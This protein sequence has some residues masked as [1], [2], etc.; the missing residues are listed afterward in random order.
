MAFSVV[1]E[2][3]KRRK[4]STQAGGSTL[5]SVPS[6]GSGFSVARE[7]MRRRGLFEN[8]DNDYSSWNNDTYNLSKR[9]QNE[10]EARKDQF[11][12]KNQF[13]SYQ[14][15]VLQ[16]TGD[17]L[18]RAYASRDYYTQYG[19][20]YSNRDQILKDINQNIDYL[21]DVRGGIVSEG[22]YWDQF[23]DEDSYNAY[24][25]MAAALADPV[26]DGI[27]SEELNNRLE[28]MKR[29]QSE[30]KNQLSERENSGDMGG[31]TLLRREYDRTTNQ[32]N[33]LQKEYKDNFFGQF[34][35]SY[36]QGRLSQDEAQA[37]NDYLTLPTEENRKRAETLSAVLKQFQSQNEEVLKDDADLPLISQSLAGYLPQFL[38][39]TKATIS[40]GLVGFGA[41]SAVPVLGSLAGAKAGA[42]AASG[43]Y[44]Y[45]TMR[46]SAFRDLLKLGVDEETA[47]AA[48]NDEAIVSAMIEMGDTL[49]D[50][51]GLSYGVGSIIDVARKG[52]TKK[53]AKE[54]AEAVAESAAKKL[55]KG[56]GRYGLTVGG[57][58]VEEGA[59]QAV[60]IANRERLK[61]GGSGI[62]D[63]AKRSV[64]TGW[65][66]LRGA[67]PEARA[68]ILEAAEEGGKIAA[69][70]GGLNAGFTAVGNR[71]LNT[72]TEHRQSV[73]PVEKVV[74]QVESPVLS[75]QRNSGINLRD[76]LEPTLIEDEMRRGRPEP[77]METTQ[78]VQEQPFEPMGESQ[79]TAETAPHVPLSDLLDGGKRVDYQSLS[80]DHLAEWDQQGSGAYWM[81][82]EDKVYQMQ[83]EDHIS[84]RTPESVGSRSI[85]AFQ[86]DHPEMQPFY[87]QAAQDLIQDASASLA[88]PIDR[89]TVRGPQGKEQVSQA[90]SSKSL[91][92]AMDIGL[93][94]SEVI[95]AAEALIADKG[96]ENYAAAKRLELVLDDMLS[97]GYMDV[98]GNQHQPNEGYLQLKQEIPGYQDNREE[99]PI[100]DMDETT[101]R[102]VQSAYQAGL[103]GTPISDIPQNAT[104]AELDAYEAGRK[105]SI[106]RA[107][108][109]AVS[110]EQ[111]EAFGNGNEEI[112]LRNSGQWAGGA[113]SLGQIPGVEESTGGTQSRKA[114]GAAAD[115]ET[116]SLTY[117]KAVSTSSLGIWGGSK[118]ENIRLVTGGE[119]AAV[120]QARQ[121]ARER[122]LRLVL[123]SGSNLEI[124]KNGVTISARAYIAGDRVF[125]R[126]DHPLFT[127]DQ[128]MRHEVGHDMIAKGEIDPNAVRERILDTFGAE[129]LDSLS[130]M[131]AE[132]YEGSG[133]TAEEIW[134]DIICDS[135]ADMNIF[136]KKVNEEA[137]EW[138]LNQT[139]KA[140]EQ[141]TGTE[142]KGQPAEGNASREAGLNPAA[143]RA[144]KY[145]YDTL[146]KKP[147]MQLTL[148]DDTVQY[149]AKGNVRKQIVKDAIQ[150]AL[151]IGKVNQSGGVSVYV[152]DMG[153]DVVLSTHGL[154]HGLDRRLQQNAAV[155]LKAG[156][157]LQN[158]ILINE[159][160]PKKENAKDS[161]VLLGVAKNADN[162]LY[163]VEFVV[164]RF[165]SVVET[166][167]VLYSANA[168]KESAVL[169]APAITGNPLRITDPVIS[170][171]HLLDL[172]NIY[173]ADVLPEDVLRHFGHTERP[174][175][176]LGESALFSRETNTTEISQEQQKNLQDIQ[177]AARQAVREELERMGR[178]YGWMKPGEKPFREVQMPKRTSDDKKLSQTVR[179][180]MEAE[181]TPDDFIP[182]IEQET[183]RE[184]FSFV[185]ITNDATTRAAQKYIMDRGWSAALND[186]TTDVRKGRTGEQITAIGALLYNNAVNSGQYKAALDIL[187]DYQMAIRNSARGLQAARI[188]KT[189]TPENKLYMIRRDI[190][191][192]VEALDLPEG[193]EVPDNLADAFTKAKTEAERDKA[194]E[195][196]QQYVADQLPST[197][198]DWWT[199]LRY[200]NMLGN[201][202]T[203]VRNVSG[204]V[205]MKAVGEVENLVATV[206]ERLAMGK[207]GRT[208]SVFAGKELHR[209]ASADFE[210]VKAQA[211]GED[212]YTLGNESNSAFV[213]G[214]MDKRTIFKIGNLEIVP[215]ER[216]RKATNWAMNNG[217]FGDE[218]FSRS[219]YARALSGYLKAKGVSAEQFGDP[220]WQ[221]EHTDFLD[222]ARVFAIKRAQELTFRDHNILSDWISKVGR[223]KDTPKLAKAAAEGIMPFRRT[224][225]NV[226][227][228]A[229]EYS[230]LGLVN[231][232][233]QAV[234]LARG[235][236]NV[237]GTDVVN[238]L[239]KAL[240][241]TGIFIVGMALQNAGWLVGGEDEE[242]KKAAFQELTGH[243]T[244]SLELPD[245][246]SIT[247]DWLTPAA[248]PLFMGAQ[249][250]C[251]RQDG[252]I[253][254]KDLEQAMMSIADPM[255]QMSMMQGLSDTLDNIR[256]AKNAT[257]QY[258]A[259][260]ALGYLTQGLT[261]SL[262]GQFA[263]TTKDISTMTYVDQNSPLPNWLQKE[264]GAASRK[265][266]GSGYNQIPYIDAWGRTESTGAVAERIFNNFLNPSYV[267][268][269]EESPMEQELMRL[270]EATGEGSV[271]PSRADKKF[272]L[273]KKE[274]I[275]TAEEYTKYATK[276][277][278]T[279]YKLLTDMTSSAA[280]QLMSDKE[281]VEAVKN[282]YDYANQIAKESV[283]GFKPDEWVKNLKNI[284]G[285]CGITQGT[286]LALKAMTKEIEGLKYADKV[287]KNGKP[288]TINNSQGLQIMEKVYDSKLV[289]GLTSDQLKVLF[290]Y[291]GVGKDVRHY[292]ASKVRD[293]LEKM[294]K[295]SVG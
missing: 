151:P 99:L 112:R 178:E 254:L 34:G 42:T 221:K 108:S 252:G 230:P 59:Q 175:G 182:L 8:Q 257:L 253:E 199:A 213:S 295:R 243:Q 46:G 185:P 58:A 111:Q 95:E 19:D 238:S 196:I 207:A 163:V 106:R 27:D 259:D 220:V 25:N 227:I 72:N 26:T 136:A 147:D 14:N 187:A 3:R 206:L 177:E 132:A 71:V 78:R 61:D 49:M 21:N 130:R 102:T 190:Q 242:E 22:Q 289:T 279:A 30:L 194:V 2:S 276:K 125:V 200:T 44:S 263:R 32:L 141:T 278:Q 57:E 292:Y 139:R 217:K 117:G 203:Q 195:D 291:L 157:I 55:L 67:N 92:S 79:K 119:T 250:E 202:K 216:Y 159:L 231:T 17:L 64:G 255:L 131:Y 181:A 149:Q 12:D 76:N 10:W 88:S 241:G 153:T 266:P 246:T 41:G 225:A 236:E 285:T 293:D 222:E 171:A 37:W 208:R 274:K 240:T 120:K 47:R 86:F 215:L 256:Y 179:T 54:G 224:P 140:V 133:M 197:L 248:M 152:N 235:S 135:L 239:A 52:L 280:Y 189:L 66:A 270:Y 11:Q 284:K 144:R 31:T 162:Q 7:S 29:R 209:L 18:R 164:N 6:S 89:K 219:A 126:A 148:I 36:T 251:L 218:A 169:N 5:G 85:H 73:N 70:M 290:E 48:A 273:D 51:S 272:T 113:D 211:L 233:V 226:L 97:N 121:I 138:V 23:E 150:N 94:R 234:R 4:E 165:S 81:D 98:L 228:R 83:P 193:I 104:V 114:S 142:S 158:A 186:W 258:A 146:V 122:G 137:A 77:V 101:G 237:T 170:I 40:G 9:L 183:V 145:T 172:A 87:R 264:L 53:F 127:S 90:V 15:S 275:L 265:F 214:V 93:T 286:F 80:D 287:D 247:L 288:V 82:S 116:A 283:S 262:L 134:E 192:L 24:K 33:A 16:E 267:S 188:L 65:D 223:R 39:Q 249:L 20:Q 124:Q 229:E 35:A 154:Q 75:E 74:E 245:G 100:W 110:A 210:T 129:K 1:D 161:Y 271:F 191:N 201:F 281:K 105:E 176:A 28:E 43:A 69:L 268:H 212:K 168:K 160:T 118:T 277:G 244:Y 68:E 63:L 128:L 166:M 174:S 109:N 205:G 56:L 115:P 155:T 282:A 38:D 60:S 103:G 232:A 62:P 91:R 204:N 184:G 167:D 143:E 156:E 260:A 84:Q 294:R 173:F 96:Q 107:A 261:N 198:L 50:V 269:V 123:F 13:K 180:V 45:N